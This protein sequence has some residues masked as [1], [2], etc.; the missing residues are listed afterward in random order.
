MRGEKAAGTEGVPGWVSAFP[1]TA[2]AGTPAEML[3]RLARPLPQR[4]GFQVPVPALSHGGQ[5]FGNETPLSVELRFYLGQR[6]AY[7]RSE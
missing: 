7:T 2:E 1:V 6:T 5:G 3:G 4:L